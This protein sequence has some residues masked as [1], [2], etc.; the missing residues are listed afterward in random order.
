M[1]PARTRTVL[2]RIRPRP[3]LVRRRLLA[4]RIA[5]ANGNRGDMARIHIDVSDLLFYL[6]H[7]SAVSGIQ[8]VVVEVIPFLMRRHEGQFVAYSESCSDLVLVPEAD[9]EELMLLT[10]TMGDDFS[11]KQR[12]CA[13]AMRLRESL[14]ERLPVVMESGSVITVLGAAWTFQQFFHALNERK[15]GGVRVVVLLY[16]L[17]P[18]I[19]P[20]FPDD[21][22]RLFE[23]YIWDVQQ[24]ADRVPAISTSSRRDFEN[25]VLQR[26]VNP[27]PGGVTQLPS[28]LEPQAAS[29]GFSSPAL[30][31]A[32]A[33]PYV[34]MVATIEGRKG[35]LQVLRAWRKLIADLGPENVPT[36]VCVGRIGWNVK[37]FLDEYMVSN[38]LGGK[39]RLISNG[40]PDSDLRAL[41]S[42]CLFTIYPSAYEGWGL[43]ISESLAFGKAVVSADNSSLR[44]A[45]LDF[46][47]Y[48]TDC[49]TDSLAREAARL[50]TDQQYRQRQEERIRAEY[51]PPTWAHVADV[52]SDEIGL[53]SLEKA[54]TDVL[55]LVKA[56]VEYPLGRG[57]AFQGD[58]MDGWSYKQYVDF[59]K[60]LP[61]TGQVGD[62]QRESIGNFVVSGSVT[63]QDDRGSEFKSG[64]PITL[65]F[66]R[67]DPGTDLLV[68]SLARGEHRS[69]AN[70]F[71]AW[72]A[73][74][75]PLPPGAALVIPVNDAAGLEVR[76][77]L[78]FAYD[79]PDPALWP[80]T[81]IQSF[82]LMRSTDLDCK[83]LLLSATLRREAALA[84]E[85]ADQLNQVLN[86]RSWRLTAP[87]RRLSQRSRGER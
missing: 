5:L 45:G 4:A 34:L 50:I 37:Q 6:S 66:R 72:G 21:V 38:G 3:G 16:D 11:A 74:T 80:D 63:K 60:R 14:S 58:A 54:G 20:L 61:I 7:H 26:G 46:A 55:P 64:Q 65:E 27:P 47:V 67:E 83:A 36:L 44:E 77:T 33:K 78:T 30:A 8:R 53:A 23:R 49:D 9:L 19:L 28:G 13:A 73:S 79:M 15:R 69:V 17:I 82:V 62:V 43:P 71:S 57:L 29:S 10:R 81:L 56:G 86:S 87:L 32:T 76:L 85:V 84:P 68:V 12:V 35:H 40:V 51:S 31:E 75:T 52:L 42:N 70:V 25:Y 24:V 1:G 41:Y 18:A 48:A 39:M 2:D 59:A 22:T